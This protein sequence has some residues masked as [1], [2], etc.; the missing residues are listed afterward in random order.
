MRLGFILTDIALNQE[1][2][3]IIADVLKVEVF[4]QTIAD[5]VFVGSYCA[6]SNRGGI[7]SARFL[8]RLY[9]NVLNFIFFASFIRE[10]AYKIKM[11]CHRYSKFH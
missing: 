6:I 9:T 7:V 5:N 4:R 10:P 8:V 2:E 11:N 1:T 3:E